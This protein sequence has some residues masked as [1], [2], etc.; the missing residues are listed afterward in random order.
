MKISG[1]YNISGIK[2]NVTL[3]NCLTIFSYE[4]EIKRFKFLFKA[5]LQSGSS[6]SLF[7][8]LVLNMYHTT[9]YQHNLLSVSVT[10]QL[11]NRVIL[12]SSRELPMSDLCTTRKI[13]TY[14]VPT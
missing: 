9:C 10:A 6:A 1:K 5:I 11:Q 13:E 2:T 7:R 8:K 12:L 4:I 3:Q 14:T